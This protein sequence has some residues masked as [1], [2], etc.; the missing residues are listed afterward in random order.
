MD[1]WILPLLHHVLHA[2]CPEPVSGLLHLGL[3]ALSMT[4]PQR[5]LSGP[6]LV[7]RGQG[8]ALIARPPAAGKPAER[9]TCRGTG[10]GTA[11]AMQNQAV[12]Q[13]G[14]LHRRRLQA[15]FWQL[16]LCCM[17]VIC[18]Y[19]AKMTHCFRFE[20]TCM[21]K[22]HFCIFSA[23]AASVRQ[24]AR[25]CQRM[26]GS[27]NA[28]HWCRRVAPAPLPGPAA[29]SGGST[30]RTAGTTAE[31]VPA[32]V[33]LPVA[34][35]S[36]QKPGSSAEEELAAGREAAAGLQSSRQAAQPNEDAIP[37][38]EPSLEPAT[39]RPHSA[40]YAAG[41]ALR[42][43]LLSRSDPNMQLAGLLL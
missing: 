1:A 24:L 31:E 4:S 38:L 25:R 6:A 33:R 13:R 5:M 9:Q 3:T 32:A 21:G 35:P 29:L 41:R 8:H 36:P 19:N 23:G 18:S 12:L 40:A 28:R 15:R 26:L 17:L 22:T 2:T 10:R 20:C 39:P 42:L 27:C 16:Y 34:W 14:L 7:A 11:A 30:E 43:P 37:E